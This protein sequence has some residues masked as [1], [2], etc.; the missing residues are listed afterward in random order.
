MCRDAAL[1]FISPGQ[2]IL[3]ALSGLHSGEFE[4][5]DTDVGQRLSLARGGLLVCKIANLLQDT[6][7]KE[8]LNREEEQSLANLLVSLQYTTKAAEYARRNPSKRTVAIIPETFW[9][10]Y[11]K[12]L[13]SSE[14]VKKRL[15][16]ARSARK[17]SSL[18]VEPVR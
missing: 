8:T 6:S 9:D 17:L 4:C 15:E 18:Q 16:Q 10:R 7:L 13:R 14:Q 5:T 11:S 12:S 1:F 2:S 3:T